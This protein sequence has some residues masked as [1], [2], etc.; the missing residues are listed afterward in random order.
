MSRHTRKHSLF[1]IIALLCTSILLCCSVTANNQFSDDTS[2]T[3]DTSKET[4]DEE[5]KDQTTDE[6]SDQDVTTTD[7][8]DTLMQQS[9]AGNDDED[10]SSGVH[11]ST[12]DDPVWYEEEPVETEQKK[13]IYQQRY[14]TMAVAVKQ[15]QNIQSVHTEYSSDTI[16]VAISPTSAG[17]VHVF[18]SSYQLMNGEATIPI[19]QSVRQQQVN[20][21]SLKVITP[22]DSRYVYASIPTSSSSANQGTDGGD[23]N[24]EAQVFNPLENLLRFFNLL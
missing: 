21:V 20:K 12:P 1:I 23:N 10:D 3:Q 7:I 9:Q 16:H 22:D 4:S 5:T 19:P 2:D 11:I 15:Q 18:G 8:I 14:N 17:N 13:Q 24:E 6:T